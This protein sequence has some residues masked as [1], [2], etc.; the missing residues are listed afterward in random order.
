MDADTSTKNDM[1]AYI[2]RCR[3]GC[4]GLVFVVVDDP[5]HAADTANEVAK[6]IKDGYT[7]ERAT[8]GFVRSQPFGCQVPKASLKDFWLK[9]R[10]KPEKAKTPA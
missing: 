10:D 3:C 7:V 4:G 1:P 9:P 2:A 6:C 8:V 5:E